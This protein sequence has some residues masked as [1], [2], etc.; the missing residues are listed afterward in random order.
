M[1]DKKMLFVS[2]TGNDENSGAFETPLKTVQKAVDSLGN[3]GGEIYVREG[4]Y[5]FFE[6]LEIVNKENITI[7]AY[8]NEKVYFDGGVV[9]PNERVKKLEDENIKRRIIDKTVLND[10]YEADLS[11]LGIELERYG[12]IGY[13]RCTRAAHTEFFINSKPQ[14]TVIYP[15]ITEKAFTLKTVEG[16]G[17]PGYK[18]LSQKKPVIAY[19]CQRGDLWK[20]A[21]EAS[22]TGMFSWCFATDTIGI[23]EIDTVNKT[24]KLNS[25]HYAGVR[26]RNFCHWRILNL[27]EEISEKGEYYIDCKNEKLY[28]IPSESIDK[29]LLQ[30]TS[31]G[32]PLI[33]VE[34]SKNTV[35]D[36]FILENSRYSGVY[37]HGG[38]NNIVK[39]CVIRNMGVVAVQIG[40]GFAD[41]EDGTKSEEIF[42]KEDE[43]PVLQS[44]KMGNFQV[45]IYH[46]A[47]AEFDG[48]KNNGVDSCEIY[49][50]GMGGV[51]LNGGKRKTLENANNFVSNCKIHDVNRLDKTYKAGVH[52]VG[53][54]NIV[55]HCEIFDMAGFAIYLH[56]NNH[57]IE[58]NDIH[59]SVQ[60]VGDAGA[61]YMGRDIS[62]VGNIIRYNHFHHL[63]SH[64]NPPQG[65]C[66]V[67]FDD[68]SSFNQVYGNYF[69][70]LHDEGFSIVFY[71]YGCETSIANNLFM[72]CT[73]IP[74][75]IDIANIKAVR[76]VLLNPKRIFYRRAF[77]KET[78]F[79]GVDIRT[80]AYKKAYPYLYDLYKGTYSAAS[81][82]WNNYIIRNKKRD[83]VDYENGDYTLKDSANALVW[84][85]D[86]IYDTVMGIENG[87]IKFQK[88]DF[89]N[90]GIQKQN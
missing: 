75:K 57:I 44:R 64:L 56:G 86:E 49:S 8:K 71:N 89:K 79:C 70:D 16:G 60:E 51:L 52:L 68:H 88:I 81:N 48:G 36:G 90:I 33:A 43:M 82:T 87:V 17:R 72:D 28:F 25:P 20:E 6:T 45:G 31:L 12:N 58:Y 62:E 11:G 29:A 30:L 3:N 63:E 66:A 14:N 50:I 39:N 69:T 47:A 42:P 27:I 15:K 23:E 74:F 54:G 18:D 10:I 7:K 5:R 40:K 21:D 35:I 13:D 83:L 2:P 1:T 77:A 32:E 26:D 53:C 9:I 22:V 41:T 24:I 78:D 46:Y 67:Y 34:D 4:R 19:E 85:H 80:E 55:S 65:I 84:D 59:D 61:I 37:M 73:Q 38:E 76:D